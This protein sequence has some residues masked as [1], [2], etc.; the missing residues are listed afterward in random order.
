[1]AAIEVTAPANSCDLNLSIPL[2]LWPF[3][4]AWELST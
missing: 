3:T 4:A 2:S 1:V